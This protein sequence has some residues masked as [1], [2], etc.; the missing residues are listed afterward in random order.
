MYASVW[1]LLCLQI[2]QATAYIR[3]IQRAGQTSG[4]LITWHNKRESK[5]FFFSF[6]LLNF[7]NCVCFFFAFLLFCSLVYLFSASKV[8]LTLAMQNLSAMFF[9]LSLSAYKFK[10]NNERKTTTTT[11]TKNVL[12]WWARNLKFIRIIFGFASTHR[13]LHF[14]VVVVLPAAVINL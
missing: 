7:S 8:R 10:F 11:T 4:I 12:I 1:A 3:V 13:P 5:V 14:F 2:E 6:P 9:S